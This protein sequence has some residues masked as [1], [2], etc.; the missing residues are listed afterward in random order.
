MEGTCTGS[1]TTK[2]TECRAGRNAD[3]A[4]CMYGMLRT[5][6]RQRALLRRHSMEGG[7]LLFIRPLTCRTRLL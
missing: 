7:R 5:M 1:W 6:D 2:V 3:I 4:S